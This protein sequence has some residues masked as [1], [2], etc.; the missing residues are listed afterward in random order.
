MLHYD[1]HVSKAEDIYT[2]SH[3]NKDRQLDTVAKDISV[4]TMKG[5]EACTEYSKGNEEDIPMLAVDNL[6][7]VNTTPPPYSELTA[8][9]GEG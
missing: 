1:I 7:G 9:S 5:S 2:E 4:Y 3:E 8:K 6:A